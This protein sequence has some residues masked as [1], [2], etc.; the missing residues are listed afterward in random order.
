VGLAGQEGARLAYL[1]QKNGPL[2]SLK[3]L[4]VA[5]VSRPIR[6]VG[7]GLG[8]PQRSCVAVADQKDLESADPHEEVVHLEEHVEELAA[9]RL[10]AAANSSS[11]PGLL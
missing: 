1:G 4:T 10:R 8:R 5:P 6:N 7:V 2:R 11:P 3:R 9:K